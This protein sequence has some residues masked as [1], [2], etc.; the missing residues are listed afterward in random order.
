MTG[1]VERLVDISNLSIRFGANAG[2]G[3]ATVDHVGL[4]IDKGEFV[5]LVGESGSGKSLLAHALAG[6]LS[7]AAE[8]STDRFH[9]AGVDLSDPGSKGWRDIRGR[10]IGVVFQNPRAALNPVRRIGQQLA[11][12]IAEHRLL[13]RRELKEA[14]LDALAAVRIPDPSQR[15][16]AYPG[17]LSGGMCQRVMMAIALAGNPALLIADEPTTGLDTTTQA[18]VIDLIRQQAQ[19]RHMACLF[20]THD[21]ALARQFAHRIV[22]MHAGQIVEEA[23]AERLFSHPRHPYSA[24]LTKATPA[25]ARTVSD[26]VGIPGGI[27]DLG[28]SVPAC[29]FADRCDR[30]LDRCRTE[31]PVLEGGPGACVACW[32]PLS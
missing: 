16:D 6:I 13:R 12:V 5:A 23:S 18:A 30:T 7:P 2:S 20:I 9:F 19:A 11:D 32:R 24:A 29:R 10:E 21:L 15:F 25:E 31:R 17:E 22:V 3:N 26:L 28:R 1:R 4:H 27:P 8:I 14:V